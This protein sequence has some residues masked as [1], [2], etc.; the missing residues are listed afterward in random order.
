MTHSKPTGWRIFS[1]NRS[2][3]LGVA[4]PRAW[5][6]AG[7]AHVST[8]AFGC[9]APLRPIGDDVICGQKCEQAGAHR[10]MAYVAVVVTRNAILQKVQKS[11]AFSIA[12]EVSS[13]FEC[14]HAAK[15]ILSSCLEFHLPN[16]C[17]SSC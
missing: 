17:D 2:S 5:G 15:F 10:S 7:V 4:E 3:C 13:A 6:A 14:M 8:V 16:A 1:D 12:I 9:C 11:V